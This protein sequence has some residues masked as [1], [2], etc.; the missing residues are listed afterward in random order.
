MNIGNLG[1]NQKLDCEWGRNDEER[2]ME[3]GQNKKI[4]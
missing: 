4:G 1:I 2:K 3:N